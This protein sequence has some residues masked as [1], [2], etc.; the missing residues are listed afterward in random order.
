QVEFSGK[1]YGMMTVRCHFTDVAAQGEIDPE[2]PSASKIDVTINVAS[3]TTN[4]PQRDNDL[5]SSYFLELDKY[6]TITFKSTRIERTGTDA[7]DLTG[8]LTI[9]GITKPVTFKVKRYGEINDPMMGHRIA[10]SAEGEINRKDFGMEFDMLADNKLVVSHEI[11]IYIEMEVLE[12][13]EQP[14]APAAARA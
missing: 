14:A 5:R 3:L 2:N 4:K 12:Q 10:Y 9:K 1:H 11:K 7:F 8:D 13:K 6:P